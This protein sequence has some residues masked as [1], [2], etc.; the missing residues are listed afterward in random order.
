MNATG[1][2]LRV[3]HVEP[4]ERVAAETRERLEADGREFEVCSAPD[5]SAALDR[6]ADGRFDCV[7]AGYDLPDATGVDLLG[8]ERVD[9]A[10][11]PVVLFPA[12]DSE[13][14]ASDAFA[15]GAA[16][17]VRRDGDADHYAILAN[18]V[19]TAARTARA[20]RD[21]DGLRRRDRL[22]RI[23]S[24]VPA[25]VVKLDREGS[26]VYANDRAESVLGLSSADVR[27][28]AYNDPEWEIRDLDGDPIPDAELPFR[29]VR[30][31][32]EPVTDYRHSIEWPDG[33]RTVLSVN[34]APLFDDDGVVEA[35]VFSLAD[36]TDQYEREQDLRTTS[37]RLE[38]LLENSPDMID[39]H[40][41]EGE[42]LDVN[43]QFCERLG[44]TESELLGRKIWNIDADI[45][46]TAAREMWEGLSVGDKRKFEGAYERRDGSTFPVEV[47]LTRLNIDDEV[48]F[49]AISRDISER[50]ERE[51]DLQRQNDRLEEFASVVSHD[52]RNPLNVAQGRLE[53]V[54]EACD[55]ES[56]APHLE[57]VERS[58]HR[59]AA[60][61]DD[62]LT[63]AR[64]G[65]TV[66]DTRPVA[67]DGLVRRCW[68][69]VST[70]EA[71]LDVETDT[72]V[73]AD[74]S[75]LQQLVENLARNAVEHGGEDV[76][77]T[78]GDLPEGF[79]VADDGSGIPPDD[80][81][82][83]LEPG[84]STAEDGTGFG[85]AIVQ[86]VAE[87][88]GW[89]VGVT[90]SDTGGARFEFTGVETA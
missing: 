87:A 78:V 9:R 41:D 37:A 17:Y 84:Y 23:L 18:R 14:A 51:R 52:L 43:R 36:I 61:I 21:A 65:E 81:E 39:V 22:D 24:T 12:A 13:A 2:R 74:E 10:G 33:D 20:G 19:R 90:E 4:D 57:A 15:A 60:L 73:L 46:P 58:H 47:H 27:D 35:V 76:T 75:R 8:A 63:L 34:G 5:V 42:I 28:R 79:Y 49:L 44:Y 59:M 32:G 88:H 86:Q 83:V 66:G 56:V 69:A 6:L 45:S 68:G 53:L 29:L 3:L 16:G 31:S 1:Q 72:R 55:C 26:F 82:S 48:R 71:G 85:L 25:C 62:L 50:V 70:D 89:S 11:T 80:R 30:D 38:A 67:L 64:E 54:D 40:N 77:V 7:I